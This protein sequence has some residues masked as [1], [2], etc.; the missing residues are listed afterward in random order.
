MGNVPEIGHYINS[1]W[2]RM[3]KHRFFIVQRRC[4]W[5]VLG[6][7]ILLVGCRVEKRMDPIIVQN[8]NLGPAIV[9]VAPALNLSGSSEF[10]ANRFADLMASELSYTDGVKVIPVSRVLTVLG[11]QGQSRVESPAD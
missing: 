5:E 11:T 10:E 7:L 6:S 2:S 9:A 1:M 3:T 8:V 4:R